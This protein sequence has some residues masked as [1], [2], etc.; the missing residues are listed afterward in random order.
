MC[1]S[2]YSA[3]VIMR[4]CVYACV[5]AYVCVASQSLLSHKVYLYRF[6]KFD[7][8][9]CISYLMWNI[10]PCSHGSMWYSAPPIVCSGLWDCEETSGGMSCG[11]CMGV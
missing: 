3:Y 6:L 11:V 7:S 4:V 8:T 10:V 5:C 2:V 1:T 9:A